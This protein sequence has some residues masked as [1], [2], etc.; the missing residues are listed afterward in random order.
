ML[1]GGLA[2]TVFE[3]TEGDTWLGRSVDCPIRFDPSDKV[4]SSVH[5]RIEVRGN[6]VFIED[7]P[8]RNGTY[9]DDDL[10]SMCE[11]QHGQIL[12]FGRTGPTARIEFD[13]PEREDAWGQSPPRAPAWPDIPIRAP[14]WPSAAAA[15]PALPPPLPPPVRYAKAPATIASG[16]TGLYQLAQIQAAQQAGDDVPSQ[17]G[18]FKAFVK[19]SQERSSRRMTVWF[20]VFGVIALAA[21]AAVYV[22]GRRQ[23]EDLRSQLTTEGQARAAVEARMGTLASL[24]S[25]SQQD[26]AA[27]ARELEGSRRDLERQRQEAQGDQRFTPTVTQRFAGGVGLLEL[28]VGWFNEKAGWLRLRGSPDGKLDFST[29]EADQIAFLSS[30]TCT[31]FLVAAEG[32]VITNRHC[33]A[34]QGEDAAQTVKLGTTEFHP[35]IAS[36]RIAFPPGK[37]FGVD[38]RSVRYSTEH[39][40]GLMH[41]TERPDGVPT[42]P[43]ARGGAIEAG[44]NVVMLSYPGGTEVTLIRTGVDKKELDEA[45]RSTT[46]GFIKRAGLQKYVDRLPDDEK[47]FE[48]LLKANFDLQ[49]VYG[50]IGALRGGASFDALVR[51]GHLQPDV[52]GGLNVSSVRPDAISFHTL[53]GVAGSSGGPLIGPKLTVVGINFSGFGTQINGKQYQQSDAVPVSFVWRLLP[54]GVGQQAR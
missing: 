53:G 10:I 1:T 11:L 8:S 26:N 47:Q 5:A 2:G 49:V 31:G 13:A 42:L 24:A 52:G 25:G 37:V 34:Y 38:A 20:S 50:T 12:T 48:A 46:A 21:I 40:V 18:V 35:A 36:W 3:L 45:A 41:L 43:L 44:E 32:W 6:R 30:G 51:S 14:Q 17:T 29:D 28:R 19:L 9:V 15:P 16:M 7:A 22:I 39:D 33:V 54:P 27:T 23:A 4:A